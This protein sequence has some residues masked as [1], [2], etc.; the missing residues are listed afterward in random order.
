MTQTHELKCWSSSFVPMAGGLKN[1]ELRKNDRDFKV[2]DV[3][4]LREWNPD[5]DY[6]GNTLYVRVMWILYEGFGLPE[7]YCIMSTVRMPRYFDIDL[8]LSRS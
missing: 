8:E 7:G 4:F 2:G 5:T 3:L 6:T 1:F